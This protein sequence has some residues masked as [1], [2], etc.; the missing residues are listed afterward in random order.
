MSETSVET[1]RCPDCGSD[2]VYSEVALNYNDPPGRNIVDLGQP[3]GR[4]RDCDSSFHTT[5]VLHPG[6]SYDE[7]E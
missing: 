5:A 4:C 6:E 1:Y 7:E 3:A 2:D